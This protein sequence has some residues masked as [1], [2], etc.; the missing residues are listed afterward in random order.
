[1]DHTPHA[2]GDRTPEHVAL[3]RA[4]TALHYEFE[5]QR[6]GGETRTRG[7]SRDSV[8][9]LTSSG[10]ATVSLLVSPRFRRGT[11]ADSPMAIVAVASATGVDF[12]GWLAQQMKSHG[13]ERPWVASRKFQR[14]RVRA[15]LLTADAM[16]VTVEGLN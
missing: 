8:V 3:I 5:P 6:A 9:E 7:Y 11:T 10:P 2:T 13:L 4:L 16:L 14:R 15:E 1:M 12:L